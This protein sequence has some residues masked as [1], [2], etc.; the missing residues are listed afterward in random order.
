MEPV[1]GT[2]CYRS[3][4]DYNETS[5][6]LQIISAPSLGGRRSQGRR[7]ALFFSIRFC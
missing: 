6:K 7:P 1:T 2:A 5:G 4:G 3:P